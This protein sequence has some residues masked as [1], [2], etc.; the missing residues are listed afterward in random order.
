MKIV[1]QHFEYLALLRKLNNGVNAFFLNR[2]LVGNWEIYK[3]Q[4]LQRTS[5][6]T[7]PHS[8]VVAFR[9]LREMFN[10]KLHQPGGLQQ[11]K[12]VFGSGS[13][14][15][16]LFEPKLVQGFLKGSKQWVEPADFP[17]GRSLN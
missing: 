12:N 16:V 14:F 13:W 9:Q 1:S 3:S 17:I 6:R 2:S 11:S 15:P 10:L 5:F 7:F 8:L 4:V